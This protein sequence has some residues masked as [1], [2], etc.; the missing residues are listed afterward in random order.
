[1]LLCSGG[2]LRWPGAAF[3]VADAAFQGPDGVLLAARLVAALAAAVGPAAARR[4]PRKLRA[5]FRVAALP[6]AV[7]HAL[8]RGALGTLGA[9]WLGAPHAA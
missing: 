3:T 5:A 4:P 2:V 6:A 1:M 7:R 8:G 9:V